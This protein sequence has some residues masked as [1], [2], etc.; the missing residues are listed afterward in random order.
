[1][2]PEDAKV[3]SALQANWRA[4]RETALV[5]RDLAAN[6]ADEKR[7]GILLRMAEAEE[8]HALRWEKK[9]QELGAAPPVLK[10]D[11]R[12]QLNRWWNRAA[13][14]DVAIRRMEAAE[15]RDK[16]RYEAQRAAG[17]GTNEEEEE[18]LRQTAL[19]EKAHSRVLNTMSAAAIS[20]GPKGLLDTILKRERW[21]GRGGGWVADAI[22]G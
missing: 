20:L 7:R 10:N 5:Y 19:E 11:W 21:H 3:V 17:L 2:K 15:D 8:R 13:G 6:E 16:E 18:F 1:M 9:L 14:A 12:R 22:Y 4:E